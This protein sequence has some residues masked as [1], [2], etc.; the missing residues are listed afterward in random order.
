M[1]TT[2]DEHAE[3]NGSEPVE[4]DQPCIEDSEDAYLEGD[5][6]FE[7]GTAR[8]AFA[9]PTFRRVYLG[10]FASNIG[11]WMQNVVLGALAW[12]LTHSTAFLTLII[13]A[14]LGPLLVFSTVGGILA[15][16]YDRKRS[17]IIISVQQAL[18]SVLLALVAM[19]KRPSE[20]AL[21]AVVLLIGIG[22]ALY[23]PIFSAVVPMLVPRRDLAGAISLNSVQMNASRV[24]GPIIG[25][26]IYA[27][28]GPSWVF[29]LNAVSF[30]AVVIALAG[31]SLPEPTRSGG[32][33]L[34]RLVEGFNV[35]GRDRVIGQS[36]VMIFV[37]SFFCLPFISLM[38]KIADINLGIAPKSSAYGFLYA[39]FGIG[40][41]LGA[42]SIGT[43]FASS[44]KPLATRV[45]LVGF[46]V[47]VLVF[48]I[49]H[50]ALPAYAAI[51]VLGSVYFAV[52]TSLSTVLQQQLRDADRGK[53][54]ALWIMGF[55]GTV[56]FG[57]MFGGWVSDLVGITPMIALSSLVALA[58]AWWGDLL[59][60][61]PG[62]LLALDR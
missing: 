18:F 53:V 9:H 17:L 40:A 46:A 37:F 56:P 62:G 7:A 54:M 20:A 6:T 35:A 51:L 26:T 49:L 52:I 48:G 45:G 58:L 4:A 8:A 16:E 2:S 24:I 10:A 15:D 43:V 5:R 22:N 41:V 3:P 57:G 19:P 39:C 13:G 38:P 21:V 12:N 50:A 29:L 30:G 11:T 61:R 42:L 14:Q 25:T 33:G 31:V 47:M 34:H 44:S 28:W 27:A 23:A 36:L 1:T 55:G 59:P 60:Q 32:Q